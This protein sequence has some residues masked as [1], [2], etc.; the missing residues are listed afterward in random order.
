MS[1]EQVYSA[2]HWAAKAAANAQDAAQSAQNSRG[3]AIGQLVWS[4]SS[5]AK[6]NPGCL[7][8]W[9]GEYYPNAAALYP[10][11]TRGSKVTPNCAK[12]RQFMTNW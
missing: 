11:F 7:P 3:L 2:R 1:E 8:L 9:T 5:L 4:Q 12:P 10:D 6:D